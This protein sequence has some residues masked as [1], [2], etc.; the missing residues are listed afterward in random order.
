MAFG[1]LQNILDHG[2]KADMLFI[3]QT[4]NAGAFYW[5]SLHIIRSSQQA[6]R[7]QLFTTQ[8][9]HHYFAAKVRVQRN[10]V[11]GTNRHNCRRCVNRHATAVQ[12]IQPHHAIDVR[13]FR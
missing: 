10:I 5:N 7:L 1:D 12:M 4:D 2:L 11:D 6:L 3:L 8:T 9:N 13:V